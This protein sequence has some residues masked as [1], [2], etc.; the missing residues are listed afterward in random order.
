MLVVLLRHKNTVFYHHPARNYR[1]NFTLGRT[2]DTTGVLVR[3]PRH[4]KCQLEHPAKYRDTYSQ[5]CARFLREDNVKHK[6]EAP[7]KSKRASQQFLGV[8]PLILSSNAC[9]VLQSHWL[10]SLDRTEEQNHVTGLRPQ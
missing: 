10:T 8:F 6:M 2:S 9:Y 3:Q 5:I 7:I 4:P 1:P